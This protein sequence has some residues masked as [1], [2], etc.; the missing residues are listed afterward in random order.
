MMNLLE[1]EGEIVHFPTSFFSRHDV[2]V[3]QL[4]VGY[5]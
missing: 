2:E 1:I 5:N 3:V 4:N